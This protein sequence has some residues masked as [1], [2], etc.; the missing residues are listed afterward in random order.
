MDTPR[1]LSAYGLTPVK[2]E[3]DGWIPVTSSNL[4]AIQWQPLPAPGVLF[5]RFRN[6]SAYAYHGVGEGLYDGLFAA[7]SKG[8]YLH[9]YVKLAGF[10]FER[11]A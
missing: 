5:V 8:A 2:A 10:A 3:P 9:T 6:G 11:I 7:A 1:D 4:A